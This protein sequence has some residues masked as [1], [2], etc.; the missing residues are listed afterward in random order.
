VARG[1]AKFLKEHSFRLFTVRSGP[2]ALFSALRDCFIGK[3]ERSHW[4]CMTIAATACKRLVRALMKCSACGSNPQ[5]L[6][7]LEPYSNVTLHRW[8]IVHSTLLC[9]PLEVSGTLQ[10]QRMSS[11]PFCATSTSALSWRK[12]LKRLVTPRMTR[13]QPSY[14]MWHVFTPLEHFASW[15]NLSVNDVGCSGPM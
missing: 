7:E 3:D 11:L 9:F 13:A 12:C 6:I 14:C 8:T 15:L 5:S 10:G 4:P 1:Q 2:L